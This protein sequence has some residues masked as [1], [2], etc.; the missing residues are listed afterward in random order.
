MATRAEMDTLIVTNLSTTSNV[1]TATEHRTVEK[2]MLDYT[3]SRI[4]ANGSFNIGD[5]NPNVQYLWTVPL[6]VVLPNANYV[7]VG[8]LES[9]G[10]NPNDDN[11][12]VWCITGKTNLDFQVYVNEYTNDNQGVAFWWMAISTPGLLTTNV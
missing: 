5:V 7:V 3:T 11:D 10:G 6:G 12:V 9:Y 1:I 2:A 4:I 8:F